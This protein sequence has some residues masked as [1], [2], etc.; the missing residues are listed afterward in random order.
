MNKNRNH[1]RLQ[2]PFDDAGCDALILLR[3]AAQCPIHGAVLAMQANHHAQQRMLHRECCCCL[4]NFDDH[5]ALVRGFDAGEARRHQRANFKD[6]ATGVSQPPLASTDQTMPVV[7][8]SVQLFCP[9]SCHEG[10]CRINDILHLGLIRGCS[11]P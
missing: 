11:S 9:T 6:K 2:L 7:A 5:G 10:E 1:D 4:D 3:F 8:N